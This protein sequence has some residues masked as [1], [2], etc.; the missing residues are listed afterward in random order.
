MTIHQQIPVIRAR[1]IHKAA[2]I[3]RVVEALDCFVRPRSSKSKNTA[4]KIRDGLV[5]RLK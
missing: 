2:R 4:K 1:E 5:R 3:Q